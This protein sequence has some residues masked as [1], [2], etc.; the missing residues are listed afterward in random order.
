MRMLS[1]VS[2]ARYAVRLLIK[3]PGFSAVAILTLALGIGAT[4]SIFTV[5][6][7]VLLRPLPF[8][9]ADRLAEVRIVGPG[10]EIYP[11]PDADF[12]AWRDQNQTAD[13]VAVWDTEAATLTGEGAAEQIGSATVTD[14][15]FDVLGARPILG[16]VFQ[17]GDD[18]PAAPKTAVLSH[19]F[20]TRHFNNDPNVVG[21]TLSLNG[22]A[23][24]IVGVMPASF[25]FPRTTTEVW[26][27]LTMNPPPRRGPFY[28]R[29]I[30]RLKPSVTIAALRANLGVVTAGLKRQYPAPEDWTLDAISLHE[31]LV[32]DVKQVL[33]VLFGAVGFLL[34]IATANVANLL[35]ARAATRD[36]E[37]ALR[38]ALGAGRGRIVGQLLTESVVLAIVSGG[39]GLAIAAWGTRALLALAPEGIPRLSEVR[40][41]VPVFLFALASAAICGVVFGLAPALRASRTPLVETL[42]EG[43]RGGMG[44]GHRRLQQLLV[45]SEIALALVLSVGAGLMIRSL[46]EL[47]RV[48]PGFDPGHLLTF[49]L[50]LTRTQYPD[51]PKVRAFYDQL[52]QR[53]EA[54][55]G[56]RSVG[57]TISLPPNL[58]QVTD[59]F[60][61]EGQVLP[62]NQSAPVGPVLMVNDTFFKTLG[63]PLV[64]GRVFDE[65]DESEAPPVVIVNEALAAKY[66]AGVDPIGRRFKVGGPERPIGPN[67]PWMT[68]VGVVGDVK[69]SGLEAAPEPS[70][71]MPYRQNPW[72]GQAVVVRA[73]TPPGDPRALMG[74][75][76]GVVSSLDKDVP[77]ARVR[78]MDELM[79]ASVAPP[80][81]RTVLV[82]AFA[83]VGLL[84]A[85]IGIY[86]VMAYAVA[87]RTHELGVRIALGAD[88]ASVLRLVLGE[89]IALAAIGITIGLAGAF[90][91]TRLIQS[92]LFGITSTDAL[93][94][95][96]ISAL[97][98]VTAL[99][100]SY[101]PARRAMRVDPMIALRYE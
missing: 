63:V 4:T 7:A 6:N 89:A 11:L 40:M 43:G 94:F 69:Y 59:N 33:Y 53:L 98:A 1:F 17:E 60:M 99:V 32:G 22:V 73:T 14:R 62:P 79:T 49:E 66:F 21:R 101:V 86:G 93:T 50:Q 55:P 88:R 75:I 52:V 90:A 65:R 76:R 56:V 31:S 3:R 81:F 8:R 37:I 10:G 85:A 78:T 91:A 28:T 27:I 87:E 83:L 77:I 29:A 64:R 70:Y 13:A 45:V 34:L 42:K 57:L 19:A 97:L 58:L 25:T 26:Q 61:V 16:R 35:L 51:S 47:Q 24:T 48:S 5:V 2:D 41:N 18:K 71:Y 80:R 100:A 72:R 12:L 44:A 95:A 84:L 96:G 67:N 39:L 30:A 9:D 68:V 38:G 46:S 74:A 15:F 20:W 54:L 36:R 92:L 82:T 23:H